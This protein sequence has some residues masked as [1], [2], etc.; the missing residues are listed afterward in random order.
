MPEALPARFVHPKPVSHDVLAEPLFPLPLNDN[1]TTLVPLEGERLMFELPTGVW[2]V[3]FACYAVFLIALLAATGGAH[4]G[5]AIAV[6]AIYVAMFFG[7]AKVMLGQ[8]PKQPGSPLD[9]SGGR[10]QTIYGPLAR[11]EVF[12]Q[13]LIV[14]A[15]VAFFGIAVAVIIASMDLVGS[16]A[17]VN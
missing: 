16:T 10:L 9:N 17:V 1:E 7:T 12:G 3:M 6:S 4:A 13:V 11:S 15:A 14:P 5:F 8:G 2:R